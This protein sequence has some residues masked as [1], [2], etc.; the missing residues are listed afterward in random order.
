MDPTIIEDLLRIA[1]HD[2]NHGWEKDAILKERAARYI[3]DLEEKITDLQK[4]LKKQKAA[5][6]KQTD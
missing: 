6:K 5:N 3:R 1:K 4:Q 2:R